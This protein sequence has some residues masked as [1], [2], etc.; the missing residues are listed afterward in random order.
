MSSHDTD[1]VSPTLKSTSKEL[2]EEL[3]NKHVAG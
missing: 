1:H 3:E 2:N